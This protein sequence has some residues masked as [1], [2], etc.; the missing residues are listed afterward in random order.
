MTTIQLPPDA[1]I[2]INKKGVKYAYFD[3]PYWDKSKRYG[4]HRWLYIGKFA[5]DGE[6]QPNNYYEALLAKGTPEKPVSFPTKEEK[7]RLV[8]NYKIGLLN[9][10]IDNDNYVPVDTSLYYGAVYLLEQI[11]E[12]I[13]G[14]IDDLSS[15]FP[16]Y[17]LKILSIAFY[18]ILMPNSH[19][20]RFS[21]WS[22]DHKHPYGKPLCSQRTSELLNNKITDR[23]KQ[24]FFRKQAARRVESELL[25]YDS[26]SISSTSKLIKSAKYRRNKDKKCLSQI[27]IAILLGQKSRLPVYYRMLPGSISDVSTIKKLL[28]DIDYLDINSLSYILDIGYYSADNINLLYKLNHKFII[29]VHRNIPIFKKLYINAKSDLVNPDLNTRFYDS[30][31]NIYAKNYHI[32]WEYTEK[33]EYE[34]IILKENRNMTVIVYYNPTRGNEEKNNFLTEIYNIK[35]LYNN[36]ILLNDRQKSLLNKYF[37]KSNNL[38]NSNNKMEIN[39]DAVVEKCRDF[40]FFILLS[41][42][43][44][45]IHEMLLIYRQRDIIEKSFDNLKDRLELKRGEVHSDISLDNKLFINFIALI[46]ISYIDKIMKENDLYKNMTM[47][48]LFDNFDIIKMYYT[49]DNKIKFTEITE[50]QRNLYKLFNVIPPA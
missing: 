44:F 6:F 23:Q 21:R 19:L 1:K 48:E 45:S 37:L 3:Y 20:Y 13:T 26:T 27:N 38:D 46:F 47:G 14:I 28:I 12:K 50:K 7:E 8:L 42:C 11:G 24:E 33:D 16:Q 29:S 10:D 41:N 9:D 4:K 35:D 30:R 18:L 2:Y 43:N 34:N 32:N 22:F 25:A 39:F 36:N 5:P 49:K 17:Y 40:G 31:L 15:C